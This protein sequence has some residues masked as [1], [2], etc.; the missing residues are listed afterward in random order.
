M[1]KEEVGKRERGGNCSG[2]GSRNRSPRESRVIWGNEGST[3][4]GLCGREEKDDWGQG[5]KAV[6]NDEF[7]EIG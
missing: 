1:E 4:R 2:R 3:S 6:R 5:K 7:G